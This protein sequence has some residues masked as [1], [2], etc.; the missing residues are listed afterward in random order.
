M[1]GSLSKPCLGSVHLAQVKRLHRFSLQERWRPGSHVCPVSWTVSP[2]LQV[3]EREIQ[4]AI[5]Q[6]RSVL[7]DDAAAG[8]REGRGQWLQVKARGHCKGH[9]VHGRRL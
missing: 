4:Q 2:E 8:H 7:M 9:G 3:E 5:L 1:A 6:S